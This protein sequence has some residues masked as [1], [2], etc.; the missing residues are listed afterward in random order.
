MGVAALTL[1]A[2]G[3]DSGT[4]NLTSGSTTS[5][6]SSSG[7]GGTTTGNGGTTTAAPVYSMGSGSGSAFQAGIMGLSST[8]LAAGGTT[9]LTVTI[10]DKTGTLYS[11]TAVTVTFSSS[12]FSQG[13]ATIVASGTSTPGTAAGQV[14]TTSGTATATYT[15]KGCSGPDV[16]TAQALVSSQTLT[17]TGTVTVAAAAIGSIQFVSA[18]PTTIG[19]KGTGLAETS[20]V[21]F[22]VVD[23]S[24]GPRA[25]TSVSFSLNTTAGGLSISPPTATSGADGTVQTVV[26][27][28]TVHTAVR[29]T[30]SIASPALSTQS[31]VLTVTTGLPTSNAFSISVGAPSYA[32]SGPACP[33]VEAYSLFQITV[34]ITVQLADRYAN[35]A[36]DGTAVAFTSDGGVIVGSCTTP[37]ATPGDGACK[38]TW[39]SGN[40]LPD[41]TNAPPSYRKGR[42]MI[43]A[44]AIG[45]EYFDDVNGSGY[46][47]AG[48]SFSDLGEPYRDDN[49]NGKYDMGEHYLDFNHNGTR[50]GPSGQFVGI[51][52]TG[53]TPGSSCSTSTL[54]IGASHLLIMSTSGASIGSSVSSISIPHSITGGATSSQ[55]FTVS[56]QDTNGNPMAAGTTV[57]V[58]ADSG[59]GSVSGQSSWTI[60]CRSGGGPDL[61]NPAADALHVTFTAGTNAGATGSITI[62]VTSPGTKTVTQAT[63]PVTTT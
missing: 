21:V 29:V 14:S 2:C 57:S 30:A 59:V 35:P 45:E 17:A 10:V 62:S 36:P 60:G 22:K 31:S 25:G 52:C 48:D 43:L 37:L 34:P 12:C 32:S 40:P 11:G 55:G 56:V 7:S 39:T 46:Y 51:T 4:G 13:L 42:A 5:S 28:G 15:A 19:L 24:G 53:T 8:T 9:S 18:S 41:P 47:I 49:E 50:D 38:V 20:T 16:I 61:T 26:S 3:G 27:S 1:T 23:A 33:N 63:I 58:V 54:A 44:T 6:G